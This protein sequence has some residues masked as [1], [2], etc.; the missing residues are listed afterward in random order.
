MLDLLNTVC[1]S[2]VVSIHFLSHSHFKTLYM[3][4]SMAAQRRSALRPEDVDFLIQH[5]T[6]L[7]IDKRCSRSSLNL[8]NPS[9]HNSQPNKPDP[10]T[11]CSNLAQV[12]GDVNLPNLQMAE[13]R[14]LRTTIP[15][16]CTETTL[17]EG[18][19]R[20]I[21]LPPST[22]R[23]ACQHSQLNHKRK[24]S[25]I[26]QDDRRNDSEQMTT[27]ILHPSEIKDGETSDGPWHGIFSEVDI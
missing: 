18:S 16:C 3:T 21:Q 24:H 10:E 15:S 27:N 26:S 23:G 7:D 22:S 19:N 6:H 1:K 2:E 8:E 11:H 14:L 17:A 9:Y 12:R 5:R 4:L 13:P 20:N 25:I